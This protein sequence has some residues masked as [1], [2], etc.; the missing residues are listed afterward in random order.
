MIG[1][2]II[3]QFIAHGLDPA[4][5]AARGALL[6]QAQAM[7]LA[8]TGQAPAW[9]WAVPGRIEIFGKHTD[10]AGGCSLV[11]AVPKGFVVVASPRDDGHVTVLD[12]R[13]RRRLDIDME[14]AVLRG[15]RALDIRRQEGQR[16]RSLVDAPGEEGEHDDGRSEDADDEAEG[17]IE[18]TTRHRHARRLP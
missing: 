1:P 2:G 6:A 10:Y 15:Q 11:A 9:A 5:A 3:E 17:E 7:L 14:V 18:D 13:W 12:A 4:D 8:H 16:D